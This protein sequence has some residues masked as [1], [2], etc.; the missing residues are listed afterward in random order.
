VT[1]EFRR[2]QTPYAPKG[3]QS[4]V[5]RKFSEGWKIVS[6]HVSL[7]YDS[8]ADQAASLIGL[9]IPPQNRD[10]VMQNI[11]RSRWIAASLFDVP[12]PVETLSAPA[13]EP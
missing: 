7:I 6:A 3:R 5:W 2:N 1:L 10:A 9:T 12:L 11:E 13:F 4:Q 8:Y